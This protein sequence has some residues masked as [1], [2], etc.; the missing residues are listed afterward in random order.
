MFR[1][2][3]WLYAWK[4][5]FHLPET[6]HF[7]R[8]H[9]VYHGLHGRVFTIPSIGNTECFPLSRKCS[10]IIMSTEELLSLSLFQSDA[11]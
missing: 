2:Q 1:L 9:N 10:E 5:S 7:A 8:L 11:R 4:Q 6:S 3:F